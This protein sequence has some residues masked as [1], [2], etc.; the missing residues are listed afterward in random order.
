[1]PFI[2]HVNIGKRG[3]VFGGPMADFFTFKRD[4]ESPPSWF[5]LEHQVSGDVFLFQRAK[6]QADWPNE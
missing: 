2:D 4:P 3:F 5:L 6:P 1:M